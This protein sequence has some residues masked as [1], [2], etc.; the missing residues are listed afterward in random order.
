MYFVRTPYIIKKLYPKI[1]WDM[2][3]GNNSIYLTFDDGPH[4]EITPWVLE[5]LEKYNA[6]ATFFC[7]GKNTEKYPGIYEQIRR[8]GHSTGNHS[9][10]HLDGW[11]T[12]N[13]IYFEDVKKA[14]SVLHAKLFRPPYGKLKRSQSS[15]LDPQFSIVNWSVMPGDFDTAI[16]K[17]TCYEN[18]AGTI[19]PGDIVCLHDNEKARPHLNYCLPKWLELFK[20][21]NLECSALPPL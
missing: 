20:K 21:K 10:S 18:L 8:Q 1:V 13:E 15:V 9:Y 7:L 14:D 12:R 19:R 17:E 16:S 6:K 2:P 11:R 5:Q 3:H 4:P